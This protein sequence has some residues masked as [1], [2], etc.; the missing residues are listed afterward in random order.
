MVLV[1]TSCTGRVES[2]L[3]TET[4]S[5][6]SPMLLRYGVFSDGGVRLVT[7]HWNCRVVLWD[8]QRG[9]CMYKYVDCNAE[10]NQVG[11]NG[12]G[13]TVVFGLIDGRVFVWNANKETDVTTH[14][15]TL[16]ADEVY[17]GVMQIRV[18]FSGS[19]VLFG[20]CKG[21]GDH[22]IRVWDKD[23]GGEIGLPSEMKRNVTCFV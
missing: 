5:V 23:I 9:Y 15:A 17:P 20:F 22:D 1:D 16:S 2:E 8:V 18:S 6:T 21:A 3:S 7:A 14:C 4:T 13:Q 19:R 11:I 12:D 10:V